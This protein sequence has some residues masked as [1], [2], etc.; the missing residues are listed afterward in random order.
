[1]SEQQP[2][3]KKQLTAQQ[4]AWLG[5]GIMSVVLTIVSVTLGV[6]FPAPPDPGQNPVSAD[7]L[8]TLGTTHFTDVA[9]AEGLALSAQDVITAA[10]GAAIAPT[11]S[12]QPIAASAEVTPTIATSGYSAGTL[13][14]L[15]N[16]GT[17]TINLADSG[18]AK[19]S[20]AAALGQY[21]AIGLIFDGTNWVE[22]AR[23]D[24]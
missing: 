8:I 16:T 14:V 6:Q 5:W 10:D 18:T 15:V 1:M 22:V 11:G 4:K 13:L 12:Y 21:D 7:D 17:N 9:V 20:G 2:R 24:N 19:L 3:P 23:A